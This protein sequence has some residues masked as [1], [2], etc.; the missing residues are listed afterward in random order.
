MT[1]VATFMTVFLTATLESLHVGL[2]DNIVENEVRFLSGHIVVQK[3]GFQKHRSIEFLIEDPSEIFLV[4]DTIAEIE[5][6]H[7]RLEFTVL[8]AWDDKSRPCLLSGIEPNKTFTN[9]HFGNNEQGLWIGQ[10]LSNYLG[11]QIGDSI[12]VLGQSI[13]GSNA[14]IIHHVNDISTNPIPAFDRQLIVAP[15]RFARDFLDTEKAVSSIF[16]NINESK[17]VETIKMKIAHALSASDYEVL[18]WQELL[19]GRSPVFKLRNF[20]FQIFRG[21][22]F[23]ILGFTLLTTFYMIV[24]EKTH[25]F[26]LL[27]AVGMKKKVAI[28]MQAFEFF[29]STFI[30]IFLG[31]MFAL[32]V[33][34]F[35]HHYPIHISGELAKAMIRFDNE[36]IIRLSDNF[37]IVLNNIIAAILITTI[38]SLYP[39]ARI[40]RMI[41]TKALNS[42]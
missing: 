5:N 9:V 20:G 35:F 36:P 18:S 11:L 22:L 32:A 6:Y 25:E 4:L 39:L 27:L 24:Q 3:L 41:I 14:S 38:V 7:C 2:W 12:I 40:S 17:E 21:I 15:I 31:S 33:M 1:I 28:L 37:E 29:M 42:Q 26:G 34:K 16:I 8:A 30:G 23:F 19:S 10:N 13:Y